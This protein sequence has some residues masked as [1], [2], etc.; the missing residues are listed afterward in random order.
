MLGNLLN[1]LKKKC[2]DELLL[3]ALEE[4][5]VNLSKPLIIDFWFHSDNAQSARAIAEELSGKGFSAKILLSDDGELFTCKANKELI[6]ELNTI[7]SLTKELKLLA[8]QHAGV[9]D[10][11]S[12]DPAD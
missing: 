12:T 5:G 4:K 6:P 11:W 1:L 9:Y 7:R 3:I 8:Q 2:S 10:G